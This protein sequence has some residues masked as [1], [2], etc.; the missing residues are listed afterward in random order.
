M[1]RDWDARAR[2]NAFHYIASW[3]K[4]WDS[5]SFIAFWRG[6]FREIG[7]SGFGALRFACRR[8]VHAGA[9]LRRRTHDPRVLPN[10]LNLSMPSTF[11]RKCSLVPGGCTAHRKTSFGCRA[12]ASIS[13]VSLRTRSISSL[14]ISSCSTFR[15]S[16]RLAVHP[17]NC[18]VCCGPGGVFLF[19]FNGGLEPTMKL[20]RATFVGSH[21]CAMGGGI[22]KC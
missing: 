22:R 6:R 18:C 17:R 11:R 10:V 7:R 5:E 19:Q 16:A 14:V 2:K 20:A 15:G 1:R 8:Q 9:W 12:T 3:R 13:P 4:E 21:G